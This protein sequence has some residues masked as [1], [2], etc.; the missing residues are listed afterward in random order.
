MSITYRNG[1]MEQLDWAAFSSDVLPSD[2]LAMP[3]KL[4][5]HFE[6]VRT[7]NPGRCGYLGQYQHVMKITSATIIE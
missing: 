7:S 1:N 2:R 5:I 4:K 6:G 3:A